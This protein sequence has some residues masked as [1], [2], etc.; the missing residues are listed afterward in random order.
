M[1]IAGHEFRGKAPFSNVYLTGIVRDKLGRKMS[2]SLGNS[3][4]PLELIA[5]YGADGVRTGMLLCSSAGNDILYDNSQVEQG[6]KFCN[7]IWNAFRLVK[8]WNVEQIPQPDHAK[9]AIEWFNSLFNKTLKEIYDNFDKYRISEALMDS[10][11]LFWD[12]FCAYYLEIIKPAYGAPVDK[13]TYMATLKIFE[14][15]LKILH[16]FMPFITEEIWLILNEGKS[17]NKTIMLTLQPKPC[18]FDKKTADTFEHVKDII[19]NVRTL[20]QNKNISPKENLDLF[21]KGDFDLSFEGILMKLANVSKIQKTEN[22]IENTSSFLVGTN[23]YYIPL[24]NKINIDEELEK[25]EQELEYTK[26]FLS[27]VNKKLS[28]DKFVSGAPANVVASERKKQSDAESKIKILEENI[29]RLQTS[30]I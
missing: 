29:A 4:D 25:L 5:Q 27:V 28:N 14:N 10:Y 24:G 20:R 6:R 3:P 7:K 21:V 26:G 30:K 2:K 9:K 18:D 8:S 17:E 12:D 22:V 16:P 15:L 1:I 19:I 11:K 13:L 23:E